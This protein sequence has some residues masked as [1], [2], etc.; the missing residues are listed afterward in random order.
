MTATIGSGGATKNRKRATTNDP[1]ST[2]ARTNG[3]DNER[4]ARTLTGSDSRRG[5]GDSDRLAKA[6]HYIK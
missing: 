6:G 1:S 2:K 3:G 4:T 5:Y